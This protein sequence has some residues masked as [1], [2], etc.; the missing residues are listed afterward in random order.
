MVILLD[1][2]RWDYIE[3]QLTG[4]QQ[5]IA[6]GVKAE[7][8]TPIFPSSSYPNYYSIMP[9]MDAGSVLF[10]NVYKVG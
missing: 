1:G 2:F 6:K 8:L 5:L 7:Y 9:G 10:G 4:F 3:P